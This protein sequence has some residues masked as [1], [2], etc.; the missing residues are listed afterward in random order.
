MTLRSRCEVIQLTPSVF[1]ALPIMNEKSRFKHEKLWRT[2][3]LGKDIVA[4]CH[5]HAKQRVISLLRVELT[6]KRKKK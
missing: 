5:I 4:R 6:K 3:W 2:P 1:K